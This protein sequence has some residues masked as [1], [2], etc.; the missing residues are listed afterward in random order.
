MLSNALTFWR[1]NRMVRLGYIDS[2][3]VALFGLQT[4]T[5]SASGTPLV[6]PLAQES[7]EGYVMLVSGHFQGFC[8]DLY[9][10]CAQVVV[11]S[12]PASLGPTMQAQFGAELKLNTGNPTVESI[13]RDFE[14][15]GFALDLANATP[16]N[17]LRMTDLGHLNHWRNAV[18]H[19]KAAPPPTGIPGTLTLPDVQKW[20]TSCDGL[21]SSLDD[22]MRKELLRILGATPW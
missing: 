5:P 19:Q 4:P 9:S 3:C 21:A 15:F 22:K 17:L 1:T 13:R 18:A 8:R 14:R 6:S 10:E 11:A 16:G 2:H 12:L 7:L 20:Q